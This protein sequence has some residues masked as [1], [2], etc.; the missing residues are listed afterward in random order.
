[1][2]RPAIDSLNLAGRPRAAPFKKPPLSTQKMKTLLLFAYKPLTCF[3]L[4]AALILAFAPLF[5]LFPLAA[6]LAFK[7]PQTAF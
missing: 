3:L 2:P 6:L 1:V 7:R 5:C 4:L